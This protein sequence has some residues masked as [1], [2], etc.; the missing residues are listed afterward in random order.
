[1]QGEVLE[2]PDCGN[3]SEP[4]LRRVRGQPPKCRWLET[5]GC[6]L[7]RLRL[8]CSHPVRLGCISMCQRHAQHGRY[9]SCRPR[10]RQWPCPRPVLIYRCWRTRS[11][12][13][14][15]DIQ[16]K[17]TKTNTV[18]RDINIMRLNIPKL[19]PVSSIT[20]QWTQASTESLNEGASTSDISAEPHDA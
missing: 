10:L 6:G 12:P 16:P 8:R 17:T 18:I 11:W 9:E 14:T 3:R 1:M 7:Q 19:G 5:G 15:G 20:Y 13:R 2:P 4:H